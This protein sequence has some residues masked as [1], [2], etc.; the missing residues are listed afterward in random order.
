[1]QDSLDLEKGNSQLFYRRAQDLKRQYDVD[2]E[3]LRKE[4]QIVIS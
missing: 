4:H 1:M 3:C 2:L